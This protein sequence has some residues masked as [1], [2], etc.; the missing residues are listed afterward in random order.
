MFIDTW[1]KLANDFPIGCKVMVHGKGT[2]YVVDYREAEDSPPFIGVV[3]ENDED[4]IYSP[5]IMVRIHDYGKLR[6]SRPLNMPRRFRDTVPQDSTVRLPNPWDIIAARLT[7]SAVPT[8]VTTTTTTPPQGHTPFTGFIQP[9]PTNNN[10]PVAIDDPL[11]DALRTERQNRIEEIHAEMQQET[12]NARQSTTELNLRQERHRAS[13]I[14]MA[15]DLNITLPASFWSIPRETSRT[16]NTTI[17]QTS[18][19]D[20]SHNF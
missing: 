17:T 15:R 20:E 7:G 3:L 5:H 6:T 4:F 2:D 9:L 8:S 16:R 14:A 10:V 1:T 12:E 13:M 18:Q 19:E 11:E